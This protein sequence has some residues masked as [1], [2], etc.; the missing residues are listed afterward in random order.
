[1]ICNGDD[2]TIMIF[3]YSGLC[4]SLDRVNANI[5][6]IGDP[7]QLDA[8]T[9]SEWS[10]KLGFKVSWFEHLFNLP[11]YKRNDIT[12][13]FNQMYITQLVKNYRSHPAILKV[14]NKLFYENKLKAMIIQG[15]CN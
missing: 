14:P 10:T 5:V 6:L 7:K 8:V 12:G 13:K 11:L 4:T 2:F 3:F 1:M 15:A 9:K